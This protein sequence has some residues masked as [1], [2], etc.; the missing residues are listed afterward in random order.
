M[1][2]RYGYIAW[3]PDAEYLLGLLRDLPI[4]TLS[5]IND[6]HD[7][8]TMMGLQLWL[9]PELTMYINS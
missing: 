4:W 9:F 6:R 8:H 3:I 1:A 7:R 2:R 5:D